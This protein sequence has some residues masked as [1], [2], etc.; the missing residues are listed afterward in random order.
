MVVEEL[1]HDELTEA[2][3]ARVAEISRLWLEGK[4][5]FGGELQMMT[6]P[7]RV[8]D[9]VGKGRGLFVGLWKVCLSLGCARVLVGC[10]GRG[11]P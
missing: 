5:G 10:V 9:E 2:E 3:R 1:S 7:F 11:Q 4:T 8:E 6:H